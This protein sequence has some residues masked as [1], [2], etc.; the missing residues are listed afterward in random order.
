MFV[1]LAIYHPCLVGLVSETMAHGQHSLLPSAMKA[2]KPINYLRSYRLR[3]GFSQAELSTLLG[4]TR[5]DVISRVE[6]K[7]REP[8][9]KLVIACFVLFGA[10]A[11]ELFPDI[12]S[13]VDETVMAHVWEMYETIQGNPSKKTKIKIALLEKAIDR[14]EERKRALS[15]V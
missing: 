3:W 10:S 13:G 2:R 12:A 7:Q 4:W 1:N 14:A 8:S 6:K 5:S 15:N 11:A 9:L